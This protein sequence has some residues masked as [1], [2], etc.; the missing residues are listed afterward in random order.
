MGY[1]IILCYELLELNMLFVFNFFKFNS[2]HSLT[3]NIYHSYLEW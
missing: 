3:P 1:I 2:N